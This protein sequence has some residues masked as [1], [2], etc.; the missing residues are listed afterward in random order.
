MSTLRGYLCVYMVITQR[1]AAARCAS[2]LVLFNELLRFLQ[3]TVGVENLVQTRIPLL[4]VQKI[5][6]LFR[7]YK[8]PSPQAPTTNQPTNENS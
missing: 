2:G 8:V 4:V 3:I 1:T 6:K 7:C 5:F